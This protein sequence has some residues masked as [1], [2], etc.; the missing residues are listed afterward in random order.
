MPLPEEQAAA[1]TVVPFDPAA[2]KVYLR[3]K[4]LEDWIARTFDASPLGIVRVGLDFRMTYAN[5]KAMEMCGISSFE[6][7][8]V[9]D[10]VPDQKTKSLLEEKLANRQRGLSEEYETE[11]LRASDHR[12]LPIKV[13]AMPAFDRDGNVAGAVSILRSL[14]VE[15][16]WKAIDVAVQTS[17]TCEK[18]LATVAKYTKRV[19]PFDACSVSIYS[20]DLQHARILFTDSPELLNQAS[21]RWFQVTPLLRVWAQHTEGVVVSDPAAFM[22]SMGFDQEYVQQ[23]LATFRRKGWASFLRYPIVREGRVIGSFVLIS[24]ELN[25][26]TEQDRKMMMA[27][28]LDTALATALHYEKV[29]ELEFRLALLRDVLPCKTKADIFPL[30]VKRLAEHYGWQSVSVLTVAESAGTIVM[31]SQTSR[32][33]ELDLPEK[34]EQSVDEGVLGYVART[35]EDVNIGNVATDPRFKTMFLPVNRSTVSELC[36]PI[37]VDGR[38]YAVLNI[39]DSKENAFAPE[40]VRALRLVLSEVETVIERFRN[41]HLITAT[42]NATPTAVWIIDSGGK[43]RKANP[44]AEELVGVPESR[45]IGRSMAKFFQDEEMGKA[46]V[47]A[48]E[49]V[50]REVVLR[51]P[52]GTLVSVLLGGSQLGKDFEGECIITA[53]DLR[54]HKRTEEIALLDQLYYEIATQAKTPLSLSFSWLQRLKNNVEPSTRELLDKVLQQLQKVEISYDRLALFNSSDKITP[55]HE[56][57]VDVGR[58][59]SATIHEFPT[60]ECDGIICEGLDKPTPLIQGDP[61]QLSF[62]F[63]TILSYL[64]RFQTAPGQIQIRVSGEGSRINVFVSGPYAT[65]AGPQ[66]LRRKS[67]EALLYT[68]SEMALGEEVIRRFVA[69]H[70]G[71]Y[72]EPRVAGGVI[73][74]Q[75]DLPVPSERR[76]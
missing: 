9:L 55:Y 66:A 23:T 13:A 31:Q 68:L 28:P 24:K 33:S 16:A 57:P 49:P 14:E 41:E 53:R 30:L 59:L 47:K 5:K 8:S 73:S 44:A 1:N 51:K 39:E 37:S 4:S 38:V 11:I 43:I 42:Y 74:F 71:N 7:Q 54:G 18:L 45:Q 50:S 69:N 2:S 20:S 52:D 19:I 63:R 62:I 76:N 22:Q 25:T 40:E 35:G 48:R 65:T 61:Y 46:V 27:L 32:L 56:M 60:A 10:F 3:M 36:M 64:L 72:Y 75:I 29:R 6:G 26:Y 17:D 67:D 58:L 15:Q 12:R 70:K 21:P 34:Y